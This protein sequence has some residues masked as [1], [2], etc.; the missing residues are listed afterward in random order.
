[1]VAIVAAKFCAGCGVALTVGHPEEGN[2][3]G[4]CRTTSNSRWT[5]PARPVTVNPA[6][7]P[8]PAAIGAPSRANAAI[9]AV[10]AVPRCGGCGNASVRYNHIA[11]DAFLH[12]S[13][14]LT[15]K[16]SQA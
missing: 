12:R 8:C 1:M 3:N 16:E 13:E 6:E 4:A 14:P 2:R 7:L 5:L 10:A 9:P 11:S 15:A